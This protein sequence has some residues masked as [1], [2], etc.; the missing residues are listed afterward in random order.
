MKCP[1]PAKP[2]EPASMFCE[3][4][5]DLRRRR[6]DASFVAESIEDVGFAIDA[7]QHAARG[8]FPNICFK[9]DPDWDDAD[10]PG[11]PLPS[12]RGGGRGWGAPTAAPLAKPRPDPTLPRANGHERKPA[13]YKPPLPG[14]LGAQVLAKVQ[15]LGTSETVAIADALDLRTN[16]AGAAIARLRKAGLI[17]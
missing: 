14:S 10:E 17:T 6:L 4:K 8:L 16:H 7:I 11:A 13:V 12:P 5:I 1:A 9:G 2:I 15:E 3:V